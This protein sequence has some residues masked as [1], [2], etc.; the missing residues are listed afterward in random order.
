MSAQGEETQPRVGYR[1]PGLGSP[2]GALKAFPMHHLPWG[3]AAEQRA[4]AGPGAVRGEPAMAG[5]PRQADSDPA[6]PEVM[7]S[8]AGRLGPGQELSWDRPQVT[9]SGA[10]P[11]AVS[12][13]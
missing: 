12:R 10:E 8:R 5:D 1:G 3:R 13:Q 4:D 7:H 11:G 2:Q 6:G 9:L